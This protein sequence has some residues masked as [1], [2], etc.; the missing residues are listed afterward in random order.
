MM[1]RA[2][3]V[4]TTGTNPNYPPYPGSLSG[5]SLAAL[6][7][8]P[9]EPI[10]L[11][12]ISHRHFNLIQS[13][14]IQIIFAFPAQSGSAAEGKKAVESK[15]YDY[16]DYLYTL[17]GRFCFMEKPIVRLEVAIRFELNPYLTRETA[18]SSAQVLLRPFRR[19]RNITKPVVSSITMTDPN[20]FDV[21]L[22][23]TLNTLAADKSFAEYVESW[24][25]DLSIDESTIEDPPAFDAY[26][27][28]KKLLSDIEQHC[29]NQSKLE[30]FADLLQAARV[31]REDDNLPQFRE[32]WDRVVN[33]WL[34]YLSS[35]KQF[36]SGVESSIDAIY[37][38]VTNSSGR[39]RTLE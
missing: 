4:M 13:F 26:W 12:P 20:N 9:V 19:L 2:Q 25:R 39:G 36:Q 38:V 17:I 7:R 24:F 35:E 28:L 29:L 18:F 21:E 23:P 3:S 11:P 31:V 10:W 32:I 34:D 16:T 27:Q 22:L 14:R 37:G 30:E 8:G 6:T 15:L 5:A 1:A 33:V